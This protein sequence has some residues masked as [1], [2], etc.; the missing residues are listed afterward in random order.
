MGAGLFYENVIFN[1]VLFDRPLRL[2][3]G[4]F[5]AHPLA[6]NFGAPQ[7]ISVPGGTL[8]MPT[9][10]CNS[11]TTV[12][13]AAAGR[14]IQNYNNTYANQATPA[15]QVLINNG[16][17]TLAQL[18]ALNGVAPS[19]QAP[20]PGEVGLSP[21][22]AFDLKFSWVHRF[23]ERFEIEPNVGIYNLFNFANW[24]LPPNVLTGLLNGS[25]G[26]INGTTQADRIT[27]RVGLGTGV[28][29]LGAPRSIEFGMRISF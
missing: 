17:F 4:A 15:S 8:S 10:L 11:T 14:Q 23:S 18:Q 2:P 12:G 22:K 26:S 1:N 6:C 5:L 3:T 28:F 13:Q 29:G 27:N 7:P 21:L 16:L 9:S 20:V 19:V 25:P 24:D